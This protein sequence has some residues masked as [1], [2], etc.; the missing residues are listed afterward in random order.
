MGNDHVIPEFIQRIK[1]K[2]KS[3]FTI[4]GS[5]NEIRSFIYIDDFINILKIK[6]R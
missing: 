3:N 1:K 6:Q 2:K 4:Q 5:G